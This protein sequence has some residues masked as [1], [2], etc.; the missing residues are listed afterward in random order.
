MGLIPEIFLVIVVAGKVSGSVPIKDYSRVSM[1]SDISPLEYVKNGF[2]FVGGYGLKTL[3]F[4]INVTQKFIGAPLDNLGDSILDSRAT[5]SSNKEIY[6]SQK[7]VSA[8]SA[9]PVAQVSSVKV[10][11]K[12]I[13]PISRIS[14]VTAALV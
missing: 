14:P 13:A 9:I 3:A 1:P 10:K 7:S 11:V 6:A 2:K 12:V 5:S 4:P 8:I